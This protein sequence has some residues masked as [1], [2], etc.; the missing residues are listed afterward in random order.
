MKVG[1]QTKIPPTFIHNFNSTRHFYSKIKLNY[2]Q[3]YTGD[4]GNLSA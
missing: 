4:C 2:F 1:P 3:E